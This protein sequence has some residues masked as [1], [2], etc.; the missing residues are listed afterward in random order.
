MKDFKQNL[1]ENSYFR[2]EELGFWDCDRNQKAR[3]A[4]L[5][6]K[7]ATFA[8]YDYDARGLTHD[9]LYAMREVFLLSRVA[10]R[11]HSCPAA[12]DVLDITT[13]ENGVKGAHMQRVYE[14]RDQTG[15][16]RVSAKS[17]WILVD[18]LTRK[19]L[20]PGSFTAKPLTLCGKEIDC[21][22]PRKIVL[23]KEGLEDLGIRRVVWS[24]LD[25]NGHLYSGNYGDIVWDY[26]P[27]DL[28]ER[29]PR[30]FYIN[31]SKEA[32]LGEELRLAGFREGETYRLEGMGPAGACFTALCVF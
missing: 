22:E 10:L 24:D 23:P 3:V 5:L 9:K 21:P 6:S 18:P 30:E 15:R 25:G 28:Q 32:T 31:Y 7:M 27:A 19:I 1:T 26:M 16:L 2:Q 8:G 13:W 29:T 17:D 20:R 12:R 14:M 11:I 4:A